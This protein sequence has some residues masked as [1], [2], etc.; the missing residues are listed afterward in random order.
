[1][2]RESRIRTVVVIAACLVVVGG[3]AHAEVVD[4][5]SVAAGTYLGTIDSPLVV[6][7]LSFYWIQFGNYQQVIDWYGDHVVIDA[8]PNNAS[9]AEDRIFAANSAPFYFNSLEYGDLTTSLGRYAIHVRAYYPE[10]GDVHLELRP[11]QAGLTL[12]AADL[13]IEGVLIRELR[14]NLVTDG[15]SGCT[16]YY[17]D[18]D[19]TFSRLA[20]D[21]GPD[22]RLEQTS[23][24][25]AQ[26]TLDG[27]GST[28]GGGG[29]AG[30]SYEWCEGDT[31]L[32]TE[33]VITVPLQLGTHTIVLTVTDYSGQTDTDQVVV[34][35]EDTTPPELTC[36][37]DIT[38]EQATGDGTAVEFN[39]TASD[40]CDAAPAVVCDPPSGSVFPLGT[41]KVTCTATD[42]AG[43]KSTCSFNVIVVDTT[44]PEF[45]LEIL[46]DKLWPVNHKLVLAAVVSG[47]T[48]ICDTAP[49]VDVVVTSNEP[50]NGPGDGN[51]EPKDWEVE[52]PGPDGGAWKI[53]LRA[54]RA[55]PS[56]G[57]V[58][59]IE[60]T[61]TDES[62]NF[63][64]QHG[65]VVVPHDQGNGK[66]K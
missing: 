64:V 22:Q 23:P 35:V 46:R 28:A 31:V 25:G 34:V 12:T 29:G 16:L 32:G 43:N 30:L 37:E 11:H 39:C 13:G 38:V 52:E 65:E 42:E 3:A 24:D 6:D 53:W 58:Y 55:G 26:V 45:T 1:M 9:G 17:D 8:L 62:G 40:I 54:E 27:T 51:T 66:K 57:R 36:P 14:I 15:S 49:R 18:V 63:S 50:I 60:V 19:V 33:A 21:A 59:T 61:V 2:N 4:F 47:V 56:D 10:G 44:A 7:G 41:T 20:A 5:E 48:D